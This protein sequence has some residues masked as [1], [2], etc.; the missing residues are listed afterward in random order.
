MFFGLSL[1]VGYGVGDD[2]IL[3]VSICC[4]MLELILKDGYSLWIRSSK[5]VAWSIRQDIKPVLRT[6]CNHKEASLA[7]GHDFT[8][9]QR[10]KG[11]LEVLW[12]FLDFRCRV[13]NQECKIKGKRSI[14]VGGARRGGG[15]ARARPRSFGTLCQVDDEDMA[16][17]SLP[18]IGSNCFT[19]MI[20]SWGD[21]A[22]SLQS[23]P[24]PT[25]KV[26]LLAD[27]YSSLAGLGSENHEETPPL[28]RILCQTSYKTLH[29]PGGREGR[30]PP[31]GKSLADDMT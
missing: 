5:E 20:V 19:T 1:L 24:E 31:G 28:P 16:P 12:V 26:S 11:F 6:G 14:L 2:E 3:C 15:R 27:P 22:V 30:L 21:G 8:Q 10:I 9:H 23:A 7:S 13:R 18:L 4:S 17:F 25:Q 29:R